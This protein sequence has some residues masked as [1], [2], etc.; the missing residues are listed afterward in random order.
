MM[1]KVKL[2][3][4]ISFLYG[5]DMRSLIIFLLLLSMSVALCSGTGW[6]YVRKDASL[7]PVPAGTLAP[8]P[9]LSDYL[10]VYMPGKGTALT[11]GIWDFELPP[12]C[13]A[14]T[15]R[16]RAGE[17]FRSFDSFMMTI[18]Q[19][20]AQ[21]RIIGPLGF[22][23]KFNDE[24]ERYFVHYI[25]NGKMMT[26]IYGSVSDREHGKK[27]NIE[28]IFGSDF[29]EY[30]DSL[31]YAIICNVKVPEEQSPKE[32]GT[33]QKCVTVYECTALTMPLGQ[34]TVEEAVSSYYA[35]LI[36]NRW[37]RARF[38]LHPGLDVWPPCYDVLYKERAWWAVKWFRLLYTMMY[39]GRVV[40]AVMK[41]VRQQYEDQE[42]VDYVEVKKYRDKWYIS[43]LP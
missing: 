20:D 28:L 3:S 18:C 7:L 17:A 14:L 1:V 32:I 37:G 24:R 6:A 38:Y 9:P 35:A 4:I 31:T 26:A 19:P 21:T 33:F 40:C 23:D 16:L 36:T 27:I 29:F 43:S 10:A 41:G 42:G 22:P 25:S 13:D 34:A 39:E 8:F 30:F 12:E 15:V 5:D 2:T 11:E